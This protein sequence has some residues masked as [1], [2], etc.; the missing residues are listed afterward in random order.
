MKDSGLSAQSAGGWLQLNALTPLTQRSRSGLESAC[1][2]QTREWDH[3]REK[4]SY[5]NC[6]G[7]PVY[8]RLCSL[9]HC[10][11]TDPWH[12][13]ADLMR[14]N[15]LYF[16]EREQR[17]S[18][19][20]R[21]FPHNSRVREKK[22]TFLRNVTLFIFSCKMNSSPMATFCCLLQPWKLR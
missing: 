6:Q 3:V 14:A 5:A 19:T 12:K 15:Y 4:S 1:A 13:R 2:G 11:G 17:R 18:I 22:C 20:R 9:S 8:C 10:G 7:T 21:I 16:K